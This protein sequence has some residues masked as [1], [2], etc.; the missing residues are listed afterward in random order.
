MTELT[1][2]IIYKDLYKSTFNALLNATEEPNAT[3]S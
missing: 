1:S 3:V 2:Q